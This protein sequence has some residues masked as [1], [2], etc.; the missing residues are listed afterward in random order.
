MSTRRE[1]CKEASRRHCALQLGLCVTCASIFRTPVNADQDS[2]NSNFQICRRRCTLRSTWASAIFAKLFVKVADLAN[3]RVHPRH[4]RTNFT[5]P[6][7]NRIPRLWKSVQRACLE[8]QLNWITKDEI[9]IENGGSAFTRGSPAGETSSFS[10][11]PSPSPSV[12]YYPGQKI[13]DNHAH[14][15]QARDLSSMHAPMVGLRARLNFLARVVLSIYSLSKDN[16]FHPNA[17]PPTIFFSS[18]IIKLPIGVPGYR[19]LLSQRS[20]FESNADFLS[21]KFSSLFELVWQVGFCEVFYGG[22]D[23]LRKNEENDCF[24][25][26]LTFFPPT[27]PRGDITLF[28][29]SSRFQVENNKILWFLWLKRIP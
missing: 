12:L 24:R 5:A 11:L 2:S 21:V 8:S 4:Q 14:V 29:I 1:R 13:W 19:P 6:V 22:C 17:S 18:K 16:S 27:F 28:L 3:G 26:I 23:V 7:C 20:P 10:P 15:A 9:I 25:S